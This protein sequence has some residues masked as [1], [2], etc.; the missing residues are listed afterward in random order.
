[1]ARLHPWLG[2]L[3]GSFIAAALLPSACGEQDYPARAFACDPGQAN[4]CPGAYL[5]CSTD[6]LAIELANPSAN[7]AA[8]YAGGAGVPVFSGVSNDAGGYGRCVDPASIG[9][10]ETFDEE[11]G[12]EVIGCPRP[13]NPTW[14]DELVGSVCGEDAFC[15]Q[16]DEVTENDCVLD[17]SQG[18]SGCYRPAT[19]NDIEGL[20]GSG[21]TNWKRVDHDTHQD[22]GGDACEAFVMEQGGDD[23]LLFACFRKLGVANQRGLCT[24][25]NGETELAVV[26]PLASPD[27]QDACEALN[28]SEG[29]AGC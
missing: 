5:C 20:G 14:G 10:L 18:L 7:V 17:P 9:E 22:P 19:G 27:Y 3:V 24:P 25:A 6:A 2:A 15:C 21:L 26:C 4:S 16:I 23:D 1:M 29:L 12:P 28:E 8:D 13:C 11:S